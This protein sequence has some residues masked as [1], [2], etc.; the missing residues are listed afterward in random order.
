VKLQQQVLVELERLVRARHGGERHAAFHLAAG[1]I[2][3]ELLAQRGLDRPQVV[4]QTEL[5][6]EVAVVDRAQLDAQHA[7]RE[8]PCRGGVSG[9][10]VNHQNSVIRD[11]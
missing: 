10:A 4:G 2:F 11:S 1:D 8:F 7:E 6:V 9:H 5:D 3:V